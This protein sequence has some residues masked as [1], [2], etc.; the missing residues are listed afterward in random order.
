M[1]ARTLK[2]PKSLAALALGF[3]V[4]GAIILPWLQGRQPASIATP[5]AEKPLAVTLPIPISTPYVLVH[6]WATWCPPCIVE[7]PA[8][9]AALPNLPTSVTPLM[10]N[11]DKARPEAF[12][13]KYNLT[14]PA[15]YFDKEAM[16]SRQLFHKAILPTTV[17]LKVNTDK[18][19]SVLQRWQ[20][21]LDWTTL[22]TILPIK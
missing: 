6:A 13:A 19:Y 8:L 2:H 4:A 5:S 16:L 20:G 21:P 9:K 15:W 10:L 7:M 22:K 12:M 14:G 11:L 17:L 3:I 1:A 18:T